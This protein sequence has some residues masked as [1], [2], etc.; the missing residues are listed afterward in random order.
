MIENALEQESGE[1]GGG[2]F[3]EV[4]SSKGFWLGLALLASITLAGCAGQS[5]KESNVRAAASQTV[6]VA[7]ANAKLMDMPLYLVGLGS[8]TPLNSVSLKSRVD[9]QLET[10]AVKEG[11][12][13]KKGQLLAV[14]DPR[15]FQVQLEQAQAALFRD[16]AQLRDAQLNYERFKQL[17]QV[18]GAMSQQQVDTQKALADQLEGSVRTDQ[19]AIDNAKLQLV[20]CHIT[21]PIDG[22]VGLRLIDPGNIVH[23]T[24]ANPMLVITQLQPITVIFTLPEDQLP[25]VAQHMRKGVLSVDAYARDDQTKLATGRLLTIDNQIDQTTGTGRLKAEFNN[26]PENTLWPNQFV[27]VRLM[28]ETRKNSTVIPSAAVQRGPQGTFVFV[29]KPDKTV[30]VRPVTVA[31]AQNN[32]SSIASG[33][34]PNETVVTDGQ[35]KLQAGSRVEPRAGGAPGGGRPP[36]SGSSPSQAAGSPAS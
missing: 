31:I 12:L 19:A 18:S 36:G 2:G 21:S 4:S 17:L 20:Y 9:G 14:I 23:A 35:D 34:T 11:Q 16:Q 33:L 10:V 22:R 27:N 5:G 29:V 30:E 7:V 15:P 13:V 1:A 8:V 24:D 26:N 3:T 25:T 28:L 32:L 6:P